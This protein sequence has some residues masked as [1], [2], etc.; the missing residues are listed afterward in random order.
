MK[1]LAIAVAILVLAVVVR[2]QTEQWLKFIPLETNRAEVDKV[3]GQPKQSFASY[4]YYETPEGKFSVW[5]SLGSCGH[6]IAGR[7]WNVEKGKMT[8]LIAFLS[9][10]YPLSRFVRN[11]NTLKRQESPLG[12][13]RINYDSPDDIVT[14]TTLGHGDGSEFVYSVS[15]E[16][17]KGQESLRCKSK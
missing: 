13:G 9:N 8:T 11:P 10:T 1:R 14:F 2:P 4:A 5:Y 17:S 12:F 6:K 15:I 3:L 7:Q 16:P